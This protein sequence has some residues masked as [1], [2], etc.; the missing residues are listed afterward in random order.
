MI[1]EMMNAVRGEA[2]RVMQGS[3]TTRL[4]TIS[5]F[6]PDHYAVKVRLQPEGTE[7]GWIPLSS[8]WAGN[9]WGMFVPPSIGDQVKVHFQEA[10]GEA[11]VVG[12]RL[13]S[14]ED[15]PIAVPAGEFWL[16]HRSGARM[17]LLNSGQIE[18]QQQGG[19][20][21]RLNPD[22]SID[23][24]APSL[25][26]GVEGGTFHKLIMDT[27]MAAYNSHTH[28][29]SGPPTPQMTQAHLTTNLTG[30]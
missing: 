1:H 16:V 27:F 28:G 13:Y 24:N 3:A 30:A 6:D 5:S 11:G 26:I 17:R 4:G 19:T 15:R 7:T 20:Q 25:R 8:P 10:S 12:G 14:D 2:E 23:L 9:G 21:L 29:N 22:G 18:V